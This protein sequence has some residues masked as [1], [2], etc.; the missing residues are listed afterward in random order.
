MDAAYTGSIAP[1][2]NCGPGTSTK[3][4]HSAT[5]RSDQL[6]V[7]IDGKAANIA[8]LS[9]TFGKTIKCFMPGWLDSCDAFALGGELRETALFHID[10]KLRGRCQRACLHIGNNG[11]QQ[12]QVVCE[13]DSRVSVSRRPST[14]IGDV[15]ERVFCYADH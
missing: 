4:G 12:T 15:D 2:K 13:I 6:R 3:C 7:K 8:G 14:F 10:R 11:A 1:L 9:S 5:K